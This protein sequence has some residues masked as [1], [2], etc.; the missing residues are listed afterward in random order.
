MSTVVAGGPD[1]GQALVCMRNTGFTLLSFPKVLRMGLLGRI[2]D[3]R[4]GRILSFR[5]A[6]P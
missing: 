1:L 5:L 4:P 2:A 6:R 3:Y